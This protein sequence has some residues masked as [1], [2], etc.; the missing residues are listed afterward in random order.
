MNIL[1]TG[2]VKSLTSTFTQKFLNEGHRVI[3]AGVDVDSTLPKTRNVI[4]HPIPSYDEMYYDTLSS[5]N[6]DIIIYFSTREEQL[7]VGADKDTG[8]QLEGLGSVLKLCQEEKINRFFYISST[9][10]YDSCN[11]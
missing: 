11:C 4:T 10:I 3:I 7:L 6:F 1:L 5:Y 9:E 8:L 2:N